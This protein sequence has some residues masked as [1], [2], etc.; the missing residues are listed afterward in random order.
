LSQIR[1]IFYISEETKE[2]LEKIDKVPKKKLE[3][4]TL[5][6]ILFEGEKKQEIRNK[7]RKNLKIK[8]SDILFIHSGKLGPQ[9]RTEELLKAFSLVQN[10][11]FRMII[12][13]RIPF[14]MEPILL[15]LISQDSRVS[16][17]GWI[18]GIQ[19]MEY[20]CAADM[21]LQPGSQSATMENSICCGSPVML[22]PYT[23]YTPY[24]QENVCYIDTAEDIKK[25]FE[26]IS[27]NPGKLKVMSEA[28]YKI[29]KEMLDYKK[30]VKQMYN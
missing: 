26:D 11:K 21:Y 6:G 4:F 30:I 12:I 2:F 16:F 19:L 29:A 5:G 17:L 23:S 1:K 7:V 20:L 28:S 14:D 18:N 3:F 9:K 8:D 25:C 10:E 24:Y 22:Y 13:G 15:P 27:M